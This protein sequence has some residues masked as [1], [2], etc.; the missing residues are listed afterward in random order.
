MASH[1]ED[2]ELA[3]RRAIFSQLDALNGQDDDAPDQ[4][5]AASMSALA[6]YAERYQSVA[7]THHSTDH[8]TAARS[9]VLGPSSSR[10]R[11]TNV[12]NK[13]SVV[14]EVNDEVAESTTIERVALLRR[15]ESTP[16]RPHVAIDGTEVLL[17]QDTPVSLQQSI[18][19]KQKDFCRATKATTTLQRSSTVPNMFSTTGKRKRGVQALQIPLEQQMFTNLLFS[20]Y[21]SLKHRCEPADLC[22]VCPER[23][24]K[25]C[26]TNSDPKGRATW[27]DKSNSVVK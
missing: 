3:R 17:I 7:K 18:T 13:T 9:D 27:G 25:S 24:S 19:H 22:S 16:A 26:A 21:L 6:R 10:K 8:S 12:V 11:P 14:N 20:K 23:R 15:S 2:A 4:G 1:I 5:Y